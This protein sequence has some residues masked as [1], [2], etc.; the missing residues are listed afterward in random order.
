MKK[1]ILILLAA[2]SFWSCDDFLDT[3]VKSNIST[4]NFFKTKED[5]EMALTGVYNTLTSAEW[6]AGHRWGNYFEG[7]LYLGRVGTDECYIIYGDY[8]QQI[9]NYT[10]T[11]DNYIVSR[12]WFVQYVGISRANTILDRYETSNVK[13]SET[14]KNRILGETYFLR[15]FFYFTLVRYFGEIPLVLHEVV[16]VS[17]LNTEKASL[18]Q[19]YEQIINDFK[20]AE[21]LLPVTN[22]NGRA[23]KYAATTLLAK[24]YLQMAGEPLND[25]NA[26]SLAEQATSRVINSGLFNLVDNY[27]SLFDASNEYSS[28]YIFD[29]DFSNTEDAT[30]YG[31]QVGT[32]D[33]ISTPYDLY[34]QKVRTCQEFYEKFDS[35]DN[36]RNSIA[37][38]RYILQGDE[39]VVDRT[40]S[41]L[42]NNFFVYKFRH[43]LN[44]ADRGS[45]W[46]N[47]SNPINFPITRYADVLLMQAEASARAGQNPTSEGLE[48]LNKVRRRGFGVDINTPNASVDLPT[49]EYDKFM[50]AVLQ[51]RSFE[52]CF[53]GHRWFDLVRFGKLEK[54][55]KSLSKYEQ[56][57]E[58]TQQAVNFK[59]KHIVLPVPQDVID[60]S[61]GKITQNPLWK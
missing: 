43:P 2:F 53:E 36:R 38:F 8:D 58:H 4:S 1:Y 3:P 33:G 42:E 52:L 34:W 47:W 45:T 57:L 31:G 49:M 30:H 9:S 35:K 48:N 22:T 13:L 15:G 5:F 54:A 24:A 29:V 59:A 56:T 25:P 46:V 11:P 7:L 6:D 32:V 39:L 61:N 12:T 20:K 50:D 27:F 14:D 10:Y 60:T 28:E 16:D 18:E 17:T 37:D 19:V 21:E 44:E 41:V 26:A 51:E 23:H 40:P 55:V